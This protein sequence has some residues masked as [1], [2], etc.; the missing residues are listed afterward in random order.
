MLP[1]VES[2]R[3]IRRIIE[4]AS[5]RSCFPAIIFPGTTNSAT[6]HQ[7]L[8]TSTCTPRSSAAKT[9]VI[10]IEIWLWSLQWQ[11][12]EKD[13]INKELNLDQEQNPITACSNRMKLRYT[14]ANI[15]LLPLGIL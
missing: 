6:W 4:G 1:V 8:A 11:Q 15:S 5:A 9:M 2:E 7:H 14:W 10:S 12:Q 13:K 3:K